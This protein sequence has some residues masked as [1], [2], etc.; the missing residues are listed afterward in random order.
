[1]L[2]GLTTGHK[3][4]LGLAAVI[5]IGFALVSAMLIPRRRPDFPGKVLPA[6][7]IACVTLFVGMMASVEIFGAEAKESE[8]PAKSETT[9][10]A[11][12]PAPAPAGNAAHGKM[13]YASLGCQ[14]CHSVNGS[15]GAGPTFKGLAG[16]KVQLADGST[17]SADDAYLAESIRDPDKQVVQGFQKGLMSSTIKPGQVSEAQA[18]DLVAFIHSVK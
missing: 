11:P 8:K 5:F 6:F 16:S 3:I 13:L 9:A 17:V 12:A 14:S 7:V 18:A 10:T 1:V 4:G 2:A 15:K